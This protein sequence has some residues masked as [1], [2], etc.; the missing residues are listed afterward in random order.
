MRTVGGNKVNPKF[1]QEI[2][3]IRYDNDDQDFI[4]VKE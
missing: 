3:R 2:Y 4:L 1:F